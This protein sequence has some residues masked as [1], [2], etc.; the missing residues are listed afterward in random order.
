MHFICNKMKLGALQ[1]VRCY[2]VSK[3]TWDQSSPVWLF[4]TEGGVRRG[5]QQQKRLVRDLIR[6]T[7]RALP[8]ALV[9]GLSVA[10]FL[11]PGLPGHRP[12]MARGRVAQASTG[13]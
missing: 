4:R 6:T 7:A 13:V 9:P 3:L 2:D 12:A 11:Q 10:P 8:L 5:G 1:L